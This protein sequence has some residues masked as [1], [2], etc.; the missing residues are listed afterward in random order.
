M[1]RVQVAQAGP[2]ARLPDLPPPDAASTGR[3][4]E[5]VLNGQRPVPQPIAVQ[6]SHLVRLAQTPVSFMTP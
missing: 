4:I 5:S 3:W 2:L 1:Q 6:V